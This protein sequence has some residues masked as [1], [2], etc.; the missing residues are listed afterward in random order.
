M[1]DVPKSLAKSHQNCLTFAP[2]SSISS[3]PQSSQLLKRVCLVTHRLVTTYYLAGSPAARQ[4]PLL[5]PLMGKSQ[6]LSWPHLRCPGATGH[7][8]MEQDHLFKV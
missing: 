7:L 3:C 5:S 1:E 8:P 6:I 2:T 4:V